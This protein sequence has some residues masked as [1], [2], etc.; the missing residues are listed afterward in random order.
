MNRIKISCLM[1][2]YNC[3][4]YIDVAVASIVQ[5]TYNNWELLIVDDG[6]DDGTY[7]KSKAWADKDCRI[8]FQRI[9]HAGYAE[10][11]NCAMSMASGDYIARQDADDFC[12]AD[13][14]TKMMEFATVTGIATC[15][16]IRVDA[17]GKQLSGTREGTAMVCKD[18]LAGRAWG[19]PSI[20][21]VAR[22]DICEIAH[23]LRRKYSLT[24]DSEWAIRVIKAG[25]TNWKHVKQPLYFYRQ[26]D[27]QSTKLFKH[28]AQQ[29]HKELL[30][31]AAHG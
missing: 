7:E 17:D 3:A 29:L 12:T 22:R 2:A 16:M 28:D 20:T 4:A 31:E 27:Q 15:Q 5:Q 21:T 13:R 23:P 24:A 11:M 6:S 26:H 10:A 14:L 9:V 18:F 25:F 30:A 19:P 8:R 1:P